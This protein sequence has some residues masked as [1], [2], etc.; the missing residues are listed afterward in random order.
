[1]PRWVRRFV[2]LTRRQPLLSAAA[3]ALVMH[4]GA[5]AQADGG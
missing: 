4:L 3:A 5:V 2:L 1:M